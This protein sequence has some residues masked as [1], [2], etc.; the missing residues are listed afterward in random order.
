MEKF[1]SIKLKK[2]DKPEDKEQREKTE[3]IERF[4][5]ERASLLKEIIFSK[6]ADNAANY[7][8]GIDVVKMTIEGVLGK[9]LSKKDLSHTERILYILSSAAIAGFYITGDFRFRV[10]AS[11]AFDVVMLPKIYKDVAD[12]VKEKSPKLGAILQ[13]GEAFITRNTGKACEAFNDM[14]PQTSPMIT[15]LNLG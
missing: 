5:G 11:A 3:V 12:K 6:T 14:I 9:T 1:V 8:P 4:Q 13:S 15:S 7:I 2:E 10:G